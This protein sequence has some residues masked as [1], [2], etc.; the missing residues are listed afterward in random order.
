MAERSSC[1]SEDELC[2]KCIIKQLLNS[3]FAWYHELSKPRVCVIC[4]SLRLRQ[5]TQTSVLII[6][7]IML[8]LIQELFKNIIHLG[9]LQ[10]FPRNGRF[11][12][13][14]WGQDFLSCW[15]LIDLCPC[16]S[17]N[18]L[19]Y[20]GLITNFICWQHNLNNK[21]RYK[22]IHSDVCEFMTKPMCHAAVYFSEWYGGRYSLALHGLSIGTHFLSMRVKKSVSQS[23][24]SWK[25]KV[26]IAWLDFFFEMF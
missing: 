17:A 24:V 21:I 7:D 14:Q 16:P 11:L 1:V 6:H 10:S 18:E 2:E 26:Y 4:I 13:L 5:I 20:R 9:H 12:W 15:P 19:H 3:V 8:N 23:S 25:A 22:N